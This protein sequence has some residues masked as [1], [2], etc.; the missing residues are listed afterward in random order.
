LERRFEG[1]DV[2]GSTARGPGTPHFVGV[3]GEGANEGNLGTGCEGECVGFVLEEDQRLFGGLTDEGWGFSKRPRANFTRR[4]RRT[5]SSTAAIE[6]RPDLM[7][8]GNS[9]S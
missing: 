5:D 9:V 8:V 2:G 7:S 3:V 4:T 6:T 1:D